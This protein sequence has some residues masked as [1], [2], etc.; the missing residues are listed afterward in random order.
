MASVRVVAAESSDVPTLFDLINLAYQVETGD[1]GVAFKKTDRL[2]DTSEL[3]P[4]VAAGRTLKA[5]GADGA[6]AG[7][8]C[9]EEVVHGA[10][11]GAGAEERHMHFGPFAVAVSAQ[12]RGVGR[13]LLEALYAHARARGIRYVDIEVVNHRTDILP[14]YAKMGYV[15][16]GEGDFPAPERL[17]RP[18]SFVM[19][20][21]DLEK[22]PGTTEAGGD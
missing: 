21:L 1:S 5:L 10:G 2:L 6:I 16:F 7:C 12:G 20:R 17:S 11:A 3:A 14:L 4:H 8:I 13:A 22:R 15:P 18:S 9:F 19:M